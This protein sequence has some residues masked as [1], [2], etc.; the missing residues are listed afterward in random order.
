MSQ[1]AVRSG[2]LTG[3][4]PKMRAVLAFLTAVT[5][6]LIGLITGPATQAAA[7]SFTYPAAI[8]GDSIV[9]ESDDVPLT[10]GWQRKLY[11]DWSVPDGAK[12]GETFGMTLP[13]VRRTSRY[14][15]PGVRT[16]SVGGCTTAANSRIS[17]A[18]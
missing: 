13:S 2:G 8:D 11:A 1:L 16:T 18:R 3:F 10:Q 12:G 9:F 5:L 6:S 4:S 17:S 14:F 7:A 15:R